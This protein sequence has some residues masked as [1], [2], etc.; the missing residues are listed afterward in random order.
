[1]DLAWNPAAAANIASGVLMAGLGAGL[2]LANPRK[3]W[4]RVFALLAVFW[5]VQIVSVNMVRLTADAQAARFAGELGLAFLI[6]LYFFIVVFAAIFPRPRPPFGTSTA[7]LGVL[8][9]PAGAA[10]VA[11]FAAPGS[12]IAS[13]RPGAD[14]AF[15]LVW[16]PLVPVLLVAPLYG[17]LFYALFAMMR[18]LGEAASPIERK[19][20]T[21]VLAAL[22][23]FVAHVTPTELARFG[24]A[25][26]GLGTSEAGAA[27]AAAIAAVMLAGLALLAVLAGKLVA[28]ALRGAGAPERREAR[29]ALG[30]LALGAGSALAVQALAA[31]GGPELEV[32]GVLRAGSVALIVYAIARYQLFDLDLRVK[33]LAAGSTALL[34]GA[35]VGAA[36]WIALQQGSVGP[37]VGAG[38]TLAVA[39]AAF[40]PLLRVSTRLA[41]RVLPAVSR[42]GEHLY[43][44]KL[45]V[46]RASVEALLREGQA[47]QAA[48]PGLAEL[49]GK[50]GLT[51]RDHGIVVS[52]AVSRADPPRAAPDLR[53]GGT[54]FGKYVIDSVLAEGGFGRVFLA[55][56]RVLGRTVVIKELLAKWR[57][58][59]QVVQRFLQEARIAGQL[60]HARIVAVF[61][62]EQH[63]QDFYV[64]MEHLPG[65]TLADRLR[66]GA[67]PAAEAVRVAG[68]LLDA[69]AAAHGRG[70]VH[71]DVK[72]ENVLFDAAGEPK[73]TDFGIALLAGEDVQRTI[74]GLTTGRFP[75]GTLQYMSP[76]QARGQAVDARS[77]LYAM[78]AV[79]FRMLTGR[80]HVEVAGLDELAARNAIAGAPPPQEL[81]GVPAPLAAVV[82]KALEPDPARRFADARAF[83]AALDAVSRPRAGRP[84]PRPAGPAAGP[85]DSAGPAAGPR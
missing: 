49:R 21:F 27:D 55:R 42:E 28:R 78:G 33:G 73:L 79:L 41:D 20:V 56:D 75:P 9:L 47:P 14:G 36:A 35:A 61:E 34:G 30:A 19:Q 81:P 50:L 32:L 38:L 37:A 17:A 15:T 24:S 6:P 12:L 43:L 26:A 64:V 11:L 18:R 25:A 5:G 65:G 59:P 80:H 48:E 8:A 40:V 70:V 51:E 85:R 52:L 16:G 45:E 69:L 13:V 29:T 76:E 84:G 53:P 22:G 77:D 44:R 60:N 4:N 54:A 10:L 82:R 23:L 39:L 57:G 67:L 58:N 66:G 31:A 68:A 72:P 71:R 7:A 2:L 83:R 63:G 62:V 3:D 1:M 74:S 46:Y